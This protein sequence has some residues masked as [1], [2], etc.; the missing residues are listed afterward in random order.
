MNSNYSWNKIAGW[1]LIIFGVGLLP[2]YFL[3]KHSVTSGLLLPFLF[4]YVLYFV[5]LGS[6]AMN[7]RLTMKSKNGDVVLV[8]SKVGQ[9][10]ISL[11]ALI[12]GILGAFFVL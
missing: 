1:V 12:L 6:V 10:L 9:N 3:I 11:T 4:G 2:Y 5:F 7:P 8:K